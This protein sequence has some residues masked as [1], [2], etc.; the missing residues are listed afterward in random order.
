MKKESE[1]IHRENRNAECRFRINRI[2]EIVSSFRSSLP[3]PHDF[4]PSTADACWIPEVQKAIFSGTSEQFRD[5][6]EELRSEISE[7]SATWLE[8]RREIFLEHLPQRSPSVEYLSL[9]TT[10]FDCTFC[11]KFGMRI[12]QALSH[13]CRYTHGDTKY[14]KMFSSISDANIFYYDVGAPW[15]SGLAVYKYSEELSALV[16]EIVLECGEDPDT[17]TTK[18]MSGKHHRFVRLGTNGSITVLNWLQAVSSRVCG[19]ND[20]GPDPA[21]RHQFEHRRKYRNTVPCRFLRPDEL[22]EY[23]P[24]PKHVE[25]FWGCFRCRRE[26]GHGGR[27]RCFNDIKLHLSQS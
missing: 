6:E 18:E 27:Y 26:T 11:R 8:E 16:R 19:L 14:F 23:G 5:R 15:N 24:D 1:R 13:E 7:L 10:L 2:K 3:H 4:S 12:E 17:I 25:L 9:A 20:T 21:S 22:P